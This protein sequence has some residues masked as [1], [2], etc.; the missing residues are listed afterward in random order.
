MAVKPDR[1][2]RY[3]RPREPLFRG[4]S[5]TSDPTTAIPPMES[6]LTYEYRALTNHSGVISASTLKSAPQN[7]YE[8][9]W[10]LKSRMSV[11]S[12]ACSGEIVPRGIWAMLAASA[13]AFAGGKKFPRYAATS[14]PSRNTLGVPANSSPTGS[15]T[16][17]T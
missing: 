16:W 3:S 15:C 9:P 17:C 11:G 8:P 10:R 6:L 5:R 7:V 14:P 2:L 13:A 12:V 1:A 4:T